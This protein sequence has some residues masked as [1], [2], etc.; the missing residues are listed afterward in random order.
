MRNLLSRIGILAVLS[1]SACAHPPTSSKKQSEQTSAVQAAISAA[2]IL[3]TDSLEVRVE[4]TLTLINQDRYYYPKAPP[5]KLDP[6]FDQPYHL[7]S[8]RTPEQILIQKVGG[9]CGSAALV[10]AAMLRKSGVENEDMRIVLAVNAPDLKQICPVAGQPRVEHPRTGASGLR[11]NFR[12][13]N[14]GLST[15]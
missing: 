9:Y 6:P 4:K 1:L 13:M 7:D 5:P 10:F 11:S 14:G 3:P 15:P 12:V 2:K 8:L